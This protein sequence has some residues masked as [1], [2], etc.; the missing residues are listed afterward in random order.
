MCSL[1]HSDR[2]TRGR[3]QYEELSLMFPQMTKTSLKPQIILN[4]WS[5]N[6][7][8]LALSNEKSYK[9]LKKA[10]FPSPSSYWGNNPV[11]RAHPG[12]GTKFQATHKTALMTS[13][14]GIIN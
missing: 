9:L 1:V 7:R 5:S 10:M 11:N 14:L 4:K 3:L 13:F 2:E 8:D 6:V 12:Q